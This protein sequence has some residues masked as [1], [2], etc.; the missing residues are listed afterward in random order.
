M[1]ALVRTTITMPQ[2][3]YETLRLEAF[4]QRT[5]FSGIVQ[6]KLGGTRPKASKLMDLAGKY[7]LGGKNPPSREELYD[8]Y[9]RRKV[10]VGH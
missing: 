6:K 8:S 7:N 4:Q 2:D 10:P 5:S 3:L 9:L 1:N